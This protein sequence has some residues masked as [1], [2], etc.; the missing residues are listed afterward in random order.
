MTMDEDLRGEAY[1]SAV[2]HIDRLSQSVVAH[3]RDLGE[4]DSTLPHSHGKAQFIYASVR[5]YDGNDRCCRIPRPAP[6]RRLDARRNNPP[7]KYART[8]RHADPLYPGRR[9]WRNTY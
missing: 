3:A 8:S 6:I 5:H 4:G 9:N 2:S 7:D 1:T